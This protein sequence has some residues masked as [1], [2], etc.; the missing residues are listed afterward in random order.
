MRAENFRTRN[1]RWGD[2]PVLDASGRSKVALI[3]DR[4]VE[5]IFLPLSRYRYLPADYLQALGGGSLD[6]LVNRL[7]L[8]ARKPNCYVARPQQQRANASANCRRQIYEL[9]EKGVRLMHE[10]G[11]ICERVA[12]AIEF[13]ARADDLPANGVIR[14][15]HSRDRQSD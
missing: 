7:A 12:G 9:S 15:R 1:S 5:R 11:L 8:L 10:R 13:R 4:D 6:Y 14:A 2:A 3:T